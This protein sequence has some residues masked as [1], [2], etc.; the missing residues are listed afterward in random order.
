[1]E[2]R[3]HHLIEIVPPVKDVGPFLEDIGLGEMM[4]HLCI[5][6]TLDDGTLLFYDGMLHIYD[7][8]AF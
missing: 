6:G 7:D 3:P 2:G 1:M 4:W 5:D 8:G